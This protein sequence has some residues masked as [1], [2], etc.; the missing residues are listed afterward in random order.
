MGCLPVYVTADCYWCCYRGD[1]GLEQENLA[2]LVG[3]AASHQ[4]RIDRAGQ[5]V[6]V[7]R[8]EV[9]VNRVSGEQCKRL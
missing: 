2:G 3:R 8:A 9:S 7:Q 1:V 6:D 4:G 5:A